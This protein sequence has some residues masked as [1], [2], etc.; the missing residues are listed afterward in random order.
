VLE[1]DSDPEGADL[2]AD[3]VAELTET[4]TSSADGGRPSAKGTSTK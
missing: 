4:L 2:T 1:N 3:L